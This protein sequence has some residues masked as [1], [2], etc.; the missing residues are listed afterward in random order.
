MKSVFSECLLVLL[1]QILK[2]CHTNMLKTTITET[3]KLFQ[4]YTRTSGREKN[5]NILQIC[6]LFFFAPSR[7]RMGLLTR[8][9]AILSKLVS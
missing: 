3:K 8:F 4:T 7:N 5:P 9:L 2:F 1:P 6:A